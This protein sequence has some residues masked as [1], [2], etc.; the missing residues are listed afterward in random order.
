MQTSYR[1]L[2]PRQ[3]QALTCRAKG[4]SNAET[5]EVMGCSKANVSNLLTECFFK[6]HARG[7][8]DAIAT[9]MKHGM[10]QLCVLITLLVTATGS[11]SDLL[12]PRLPRRAG[13]IVRIR[14]RED[15]V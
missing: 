2:A 1:K 13:Q 8:P 9:A 6:L 3:V 11:G 15:L 7:C 10:I 4:L 5:A 12:R 14:N